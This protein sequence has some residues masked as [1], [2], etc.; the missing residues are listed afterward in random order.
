[1]IGLKY[2]TQT[3]EMVIN[4]G[5]F[6][7][8][9]RCDVQNGAIILESKS[10]FLSNPQLGIGIEQT[11]GSSESTRVV[12]LNRWVIQAEQDGAS[13]AKWNTNNDNT[14]NIEISYD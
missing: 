12:E 5:D 13:I 4:N 7:I 2:N 10:A 9:P 8:N 11:I 14:I 6:E 1:M 3:R